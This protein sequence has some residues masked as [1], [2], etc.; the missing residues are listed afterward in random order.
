MNRVATLGLFTLLSIPS[1]SSV[2]LADRQMGPMV[3]DAK[4]HIRTYVM[5]DPDT[6]PTIPTSE[7][8]AEGGIPGI[9]HVI[10]LNN[11]KPG[12]CALTPGGNGPAGQSSIIG[13]AVNIA[14][15]S[16]SDAVWQQVVQCV[17]DTYQPFGVTIVTTRPAGGNYHTAIVAGS[18]GQ[19]G[20]DP[21]VLGV[22]PF[23]CG[24]LENAISFTFANET[25]GNVADQCWTVAQETAHSWGLDHKFDNK[26]PMTYLQS[27]PAL[28]RFQNAAGSCGE[29]SARACQCGGNTMNSYAEVLATFGAAAPDTVPPT[30]VVSAPADGS[31]QEPGFAIR[32]TVSDDVGLTEVEAKVDGM[33]V[34]KVYAFPFVW[35]APATLAMGSHR[36]EVAAKDLMGNVTKKTVNV[37]YGSKCTA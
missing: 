19:A 22:S 32:A 5:V 26:D 27:G 6:N 3:P 28:K 35:N 33:S 37:V 23:S 2:A 10:Y 1:I 34:G 8:T 11:C 13:G 12:G 30:V 20:M 15:Y 4:G 21:G 9:S 29:Y 14:A 7:G 25:P 31:T 36:V 17:K 24:F 18:P 16:G